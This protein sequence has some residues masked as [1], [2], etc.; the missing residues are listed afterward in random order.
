MAQ[1]SQRVELPVT[2][3]NKITED[4]PHAVS[5]IRADVVY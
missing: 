2:C 1:F 4:S 3:V 5:L